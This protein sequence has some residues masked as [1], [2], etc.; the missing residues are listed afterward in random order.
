MRNV[1]ASRNVVAV[2][3]ECQA[4]SVA[5]DALETA[6]RE[7]LGV[8]AQVAREAA[9][10]ILSRCHRRVRGLA[11][12]WIAPL[13]HIEDAAIRGG[14]WRDREV[15]LASVHVATLGR[16]L[17]DLAARLAH[18]LHGVRGWSGHAALAT[19]M[20]HRMAE[21]D[22]GN[23]MMLFQTPAIAGALVELV[24][25]CAAHPS[26]GTWPECDLGRFDKVLEDSIGVP[27]VEWWRSLLA[28]DADTDHEGLLPAVSFFLRPSRDAARLRE[29]SLRSRMASVM[30]E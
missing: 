12:L 5:V 25:R 27:P 16:P 18:P 21:G 29:R 30:R 22:S 2:P 24:D 15:P 26:A 13:N 17:S 8:D 3:M 28:E 6:W 1:A 4:P 19:L 10:R 20:L 14:S 7:E 11:Q 23:W 9:T